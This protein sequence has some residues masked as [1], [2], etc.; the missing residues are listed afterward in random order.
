[1]EIKE[2]S[3]S[4]YQQS[5]IQHNE[6]YLKIFVKMSALIVYLVCLNKLKNKLQ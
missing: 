6:K 3:K 2:R 5:R 1:M 4:Y